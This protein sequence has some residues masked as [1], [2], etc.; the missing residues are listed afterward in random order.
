MREKDR[1]TG[2]SPTVT[3]T[4]GL[5]GKP[6]GA[7]TTGTG[8]SDDQI[9]KSTGIPAKKQHRKSQDR[10]SRQTGRGRKTKLSPNK[11]RSV[12]KRMETHKIMR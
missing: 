5:T 4:K 2:T 6:G 12:M 3:K 7:I 9:T 8:D 11:K 10:R 1:S